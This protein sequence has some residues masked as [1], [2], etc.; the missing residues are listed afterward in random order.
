MDDD[1]ALNEMAAVI[2]IIS[3]VIVMAALVFILSSGMLSNLTKP[4][5]IAPKISAQTISGKDVIDISNRGGDVIYL[6]V[7]KLHYNEMGVYID[8]PEGSY[9]ARPLPGVDQFSPGTTLYL[10]KGPD[11][12]RITDNPVDLASASAGSV[13]AG[14][15]AVRLVDETSQL[16]LATWGNA[17][18]SSPAPVPTPTPTLPPS[19]GPVKAAFT[20]D[21]A[22]GIVPFSVWFTDASTGPV[23][24]WYW[25]FGD[26]STT[27]EQSPSHLYLKTGEYTVSLKVT[28][29][30]GG[31]DT[32]TYPGCVRGIIRA[33]FAATPV[34]GPAP[35]AVQF[36][37]TSGPDAQ[38][39]LWDFGDGVTANSSQRNPVHIFRNS[40]TYTVKLTASGAGGS[41][42]AIKPGYITVQDLP[43][44]VAGFS[45][46]PV[47]GT[48]P[49]TVAFTDTS[50]NNPTTWSWDFGDGDT[51]GTTL[52]NPVHTYTKPGSYTV[53]LQSA[54]A[55]G[56]SGILTRQGYI[57]VSSSTL[58]PTISWVWPDNLRHGQSHTDVDLEGTGFV[59]AGTTRVTLRHAGEK[60]IEGEWVKVL[61]PTHLIFDLHVPGS[62][63]PG[64]WDVIVTN[65]DGR[66]CTLKGGFE[67][68]S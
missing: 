27:D 58:P 5:L 53:T 25:T 49:L 8:T 19:P 34:S 51:T 42:T 15:V 17:E 52:Q 24:S 68:R 63:D 1:R 38:T 47:S 29:A 62:A 43:L 13:P 31:A 14:Q 20:R 4:T 39:L 55:G 22:E 45:A 35:L 67:V 66:S 6:N 44:P 2:L 21:P 64:D 26:G 50:T 40:G 60:D 57:T 61:R 11:A 32:F 18:G 10:F 59:E 37:D 36:T 33:D 3:L 28:N 54:N 46:I 9:R 23:T 12:Y 41:D 48:A 30:T 65:P 16:L 7:P 56:K